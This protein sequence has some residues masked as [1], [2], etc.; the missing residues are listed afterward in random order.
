MLA[1]AFSV[2]IKFITNYEFFIIFY[3]LLILYVFF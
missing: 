3:I 2:I 1:I